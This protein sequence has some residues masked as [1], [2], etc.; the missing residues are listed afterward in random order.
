V[1]VQAG[2]TPDPTPGYDEAQT[3]AAD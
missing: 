2:G 1:R 3:L